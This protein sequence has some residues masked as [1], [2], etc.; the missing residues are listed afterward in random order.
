MSKEI[1]LQLTALHPAQWQVVQQAKR[2]NVV[3]CGRRWGKTVLGMD[4]LIH[5]ALQSKPVAWFAPNYRLLSD[6]WRELQVTLEP[7]IA[8]TNQQE[9][10]L[11]L[12]GAGVVEMWSL[13]SP[14][15]GRGRAYGR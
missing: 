10:R 6:V 11:A 3:C 13:A 8:R 5:P 14:G 12:R 1:E 9:R 2:F 15:S 4:R 7:V